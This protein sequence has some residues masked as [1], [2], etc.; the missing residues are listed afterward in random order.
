M[1]SRS[2]RAAGTS[3]ESGR[4]AT[5]SS[6]SASASLDRASP[7][8]KAS[9]SCLS[10]L[11]T[12]SLTALV[13]VGGAAIKWP[14]AWSQVGV[15]F[16]QLHYYDWVYEWF[17]YETVT[18]ASVGLTSKPVVM[19]E[20]PI[21]GLSAIPSKSLPAVSAAQFAAGLWTAGYGGALAWAFNDSSFPWS[22]SALLTFASQ[23]ACETKY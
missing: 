18:L 4:Q 1:P 2:E 9:G 13:S 12:T 7:T 16:Y 22:P 3:D 23:H 20:F 11:T 8:T 10:G 5:R 6:P 19:G 17:P 15:D 14:K 21:Q